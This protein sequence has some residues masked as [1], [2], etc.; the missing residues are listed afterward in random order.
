MVNQN[1]VENHFKK[2]WNGKYI[3]WGLC[4]HMLTLSLYMYYIVYILSI[5]HLLFI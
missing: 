1:L 2:S 3:I 5:T 4:T